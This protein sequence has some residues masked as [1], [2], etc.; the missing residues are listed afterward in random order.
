MGFIKETPPP[1]ECEE[2]NVFK[3]R[4]VE[5]KK[6]TSTWKD[7]EREQLQFDCQLDNA[8]KVRVWAAYYEQPGEK[9]TLGKLALKLQQATKHEFSNIDEFIAAL[10][11]FGSLFL[12][13][14]GFRE[15]EET[16]YPNF[17]I[18]TDKLPS[19]QEKLSTEPKKER[20]E[21]KNVKVIL[22]GFKDIITLGVPL[23]L[24]DLTNSVTIT[25]RLTLFKDGLIE[26]KEDLYFF[27]DKAKEILKNAL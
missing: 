27:T 3:A 1:P 21:G 23:S 16:M 19:L 13:V 18:V 17:A 26:K 4:I 25:D 11:T 7:E 14:K 20:T 15:F 9:S 10:K 12:R 24:N 2:G 6:V 8:Y 5:I 22:E